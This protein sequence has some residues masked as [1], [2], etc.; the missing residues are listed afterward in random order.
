MMAIMTIAQGVVE[1]FDYK[2]FQFQEY[3]F[4]I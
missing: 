2:E 3:T 4:K 1:G